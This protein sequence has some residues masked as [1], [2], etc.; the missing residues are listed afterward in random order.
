M[1]LRSLR[2]MGTP[3]QTL[4]ELHGLVDGLVRSMY[5]GEIGEGRRTGRGEEEGVKERRGIAFI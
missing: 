2:A 1:L 3:K 4:H 5:R